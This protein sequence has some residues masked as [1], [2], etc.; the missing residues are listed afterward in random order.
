METIVGLIMLDGQLE[1][2]SL[3]NTAWTWIILCNIEY[4]D[5][6]INVSVRI[7]VTL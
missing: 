4:R 3:N 7:I 1:K 2:S 6:G 5:T